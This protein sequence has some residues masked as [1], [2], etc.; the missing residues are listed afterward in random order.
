MP[1]WETIVSLLGLLGGAVA[2][3]AVRRE[4]RELRAR[5]ERDWKLLKELSE[6]PHAPEGARTAMTAAVV[7]QAQ[8]LEA[9][10]VKGPALAIRLLFQLGLGMV[11]FGLVAHLA[12][13]LTYVVAASDGPVSRTWESVVFVGEVLA[14]STAAAGASVSIIGLILALRT[15]PREE[16]RRGRS[17]GRRSSAPPSPIA[18]PTI[19]AATSDALPA[20]IPRSCSARES[21]VKQV[22]PAQPSR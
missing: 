10:V 14:V 13:A 2:W 17:R 8:E 9:S 16:R 22:G 15:V 4:R 11:M 19:S 21:G 3:I 5:L 20:P 12:V 18:G 7:H 1:D 6:S